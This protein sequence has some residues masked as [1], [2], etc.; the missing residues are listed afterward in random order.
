MASGLAARGE[1]RP[2]GPG[3]GGPRRARPRRGPRR[4]RPR[5]G[6]GR[7]SAPAPVVVVGPACVEETQRE[8]ERTQVWVPC[9]VGRK[10]PAAFGYYV[11]ERFSPVKVLCTT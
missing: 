7:T 10:M 9:I 1:L 5:R 11:G 4:A 3:A 6:R 8:G 2:G